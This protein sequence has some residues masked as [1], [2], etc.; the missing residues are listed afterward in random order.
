MSLRY[1]YEQYSSEV[2]ELLKQGYG[3]DAIYR[4]I[5]EQC[6]KSYNAVKKSI[7][8]RGFQNVFCEVPK[9]GTMQVSKMSD[10]SYQYPPQIIATK[11][12]RDTI[13]DEIPT[14]ESPT[15]E[16]KTMP[17]GI[18]K[19]AILTD[20]HLPYHNKEALL[21][22]VKHIRDFEPDTILLNGDILDFEKLSRF[23]TSPR[24]PDVV[25]ELDMWKAFAK[26]LRD[27][28]P[29]TNIY[30]RNG[31][32]EL[33]LL[34]YVRRNAA[35]LEG[36]VD[37]EQIMQFNNFGIKFVDNVIGMNF[38]ELCV[39]HGHEVYGGVGAINIAKVVLDRTHINSA[40]GHFHRTQEFS[41]KSAHDKVIACWSIGCLQEHRVDYMPVNQW[42][43]GFAL[44]EFEKDGKFHFM[45]K[46]IIDGKVR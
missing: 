41:R 44:V 43:Y 5:A 16:Y 23:V 36:L 19:L 7:C 18:R 10:Y 27:Y 3:R 8:S 22:A 45:N 2:Q 11:I 26:W 30:F 21:A 12:H 38:G 9:M 35:A 25:F 40:I 28:F 46:K 34:M 15:L 14:P 42:N 17:S 39:Y 31:N 13:G 29:N 6:G 4:W 20:I 33:R 1:P 32:H 24:K 37:F